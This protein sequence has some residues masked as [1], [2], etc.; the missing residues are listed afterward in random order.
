MDKGG[1]DEDHRTR[2]DRSG[3]RKKGEEQKREG[4]LTPAGR[5][6]YKEGGV[7]GGTVRQR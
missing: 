1:K 4:G 6:M 5:Y 3:R 2:R 7:G